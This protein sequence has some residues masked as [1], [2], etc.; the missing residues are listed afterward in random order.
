[1]TYPQSPLYEIECKGKT[2]FA[3]SEEDPIVY[4]LKMTLIADFGYRF[5]ADYSD[6][7]LTIPGLTTATDQSY[8]KLDGTETTGVVM[9]DQLVTTAERASSLAIQT[10]RRRA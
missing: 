1:M 10:R 2:Y 9:L 6:V 4:R 7:T 3:Y 5:P 8:V